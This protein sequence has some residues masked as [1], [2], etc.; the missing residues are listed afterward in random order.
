MSICSAG[1]R[2][3]RNFVTRIEIPVA[4]LPAFLCPGL[5]RTAYTRPRT[6]RTHC[7]Y[8]SKPAQRRCVST[9]TTSVVK[10]NRDVPIEIVKKLPRQCPGCGAHTQFVDKE[11]AGYY[12]TTRTSLQTFLGINPVQDASAEDTIIS[13]ALKN[14]GEAA[15]SIAFKKQKRTILLLLST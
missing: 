13:A 2:T 12:T 3:A 11:E 14:A 6:P 9:E 5:L 10:A 1:A 4:E 15:S 8:I 7:R